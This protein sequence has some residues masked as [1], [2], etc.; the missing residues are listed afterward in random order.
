MSYIYFLRDPIYKR[1]KIGFTDH[2]RSRI[3]SIQT[4]SPGELE[5]LAVFFCTGIAEEQRLH[6]KF[7]KYR[8]HGEWFQEH[9][10]ILKE[11]ARRGIELSLSDKEERFKP[12]RRRDDL[13]VELSARSMDVYEMSE[14]LGVSVRSAHRY[15]VLL[16]ESESLVG[17]IVGHRKVW[18]LAGGSSR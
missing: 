15:L 6:V 11:A 12:M 7:K 8:L 16:Q 5:V 17:H 9:K 2:P 10:S 14:F 4:T 3:R 18:R 13:V 1:I